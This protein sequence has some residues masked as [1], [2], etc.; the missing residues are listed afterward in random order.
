LLVD[1]RFDAG[2]SI[3]LPA[4]AAEHALFVIEGELRV[5]ADA[6]AANR[7][8]VLCSG[9]PAR[10]TATTPA[11]A[12]WLGGPPPGARVIEWNFVASS[13]ERLERARDKWK[14]R[15]FPAIPSD[16]EEFIPW[17]ENLR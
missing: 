9:K 6:L 4:D 16:D 10:A 14:A 5:G 13:R 3:E 17:P 11:R 12:M 8:A 2:A 7:L 1:L 15:E